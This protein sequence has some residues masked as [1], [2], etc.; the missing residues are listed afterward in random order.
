MTKL[1]LIKNIYLLEKKQYENKEEL[2]NYVASLSDDPV[3]Q[4]YSETVKQV[5][6]QN[7]KYEKTKLALA[8][9]Y[10]ETLENTKI[11]DQEKIDEMFNNIADLLLGGEG[12]L[13]DLRDTM[14]LGEEMA[15]DLF[16]SEDDEDEEEG[17]TVK[18]DGWSWDDED[19]D[20]THKC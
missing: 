1:E 8:K 14:K 3:W 12:H 13:Q 5:L 18:N 17:D 6:K 19:D 9:N 11:D 2:C 10:I 7:L 15:S 4:I 16:D 20:N